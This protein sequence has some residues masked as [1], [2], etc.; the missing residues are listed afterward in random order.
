MPAIKV[1]NVSFAYGSSQAL[2][3]VSFSVEKGEIFGLLGPNGGGKT[4]LFRILCTLLAPQNGRVEVLGVDVGQEPLRVRKE[5]GVV[6]QSSS[7][8]KELTVRENLVHQ[9]HLYGLRGKDLV[10]RIGGIMKEFGLESRSSDRVKILSG[11]FQRRV[12]LAKGLLHS[13][14]VMLLDEPTVGL[15]P[16]ARYDFWSFLENLRDCHSMTILLTTH[17][18]D[19][20]ERCDSLGILSSG[21]LVTLGEPQV[22][23]EKIGGTV[24]TVRSDDPESLRDQIQKEFSCQPL[25]IEDAVRIESARGTEL[26]AELMVAFPEQILAVTVG[27]PTLEDVFV[28]ETGHAMREEESLGVE[29]D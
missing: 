16:G 19:E 18:M 11:G 12:E 6:F 15:D 24:V 10:K 25:V 26:S 23:K 2:D 8:D 3:G 22:L 9:G 21:K 7:L 28:H 4:T 5:V 29:K 17:L 27:K 14:R 13:P 20:A 1:E